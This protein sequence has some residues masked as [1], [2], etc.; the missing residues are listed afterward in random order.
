MLRRPDVA[1]A[2]ARQGLDPLGSTQGD[3]ERHLKSEIAKWGKVVRD[4]KAQ[5]N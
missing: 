2:I 4:V 5:V 1:Q 3:F